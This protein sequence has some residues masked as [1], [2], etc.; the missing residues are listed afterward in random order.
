MIIW[1][2]HGNTSDLNAGTTVCIVRT[3][4]V[5]GVFRRSDRFKVHNF[6]RRPPVVH[7]RSDVELAVA[8][9]DSYPGSQYRCQ[10]LS[11]DIFYLL[12]MVAVRRVEKLLIPVL[13][14]QNIDQ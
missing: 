5:N 4:E 1:S 11:H 14:T 3:E 8:M 9:N 6:H 2:M 10:F 12:K 7:R 13:L